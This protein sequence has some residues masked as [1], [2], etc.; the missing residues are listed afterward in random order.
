[1][2]IPMDSAFSFTMGHVFAV[3]RR[4]TL[5]DDV[6]K[7]RACLHRSRL[8]EVLVFVPLGMY[9]WLRWPDWTWMYLVDRS[10]SLLLAA[11]GLSL[12]PISHELGYRNAMRLIKAGRSDKALTHCAAS[13]VVLALV[14]AFGWR[15]FRWQ[16]TTADFINGNAVDVF[17]SRDFQISM[18]VA[19]AIFTAA[20]AAVVV[21]N[22]S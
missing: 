19:A 15:R 3:A 13:L 16:G 1:M 10:R 4:D 6:E 12:Y 9:F 11:L 21:K 7:E 22:N 20:A 5:R 14:S 2:T 8:F 18:L 17:S